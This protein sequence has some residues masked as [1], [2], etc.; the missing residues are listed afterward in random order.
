MPFRWRC[1]A[2]TENK[3]F[4]S[5]QHLKADRL[6]ARFP[7]AAFVVCVAR[8]ASFAQCSLSSR[9]HCFP[10]LAF[11]YLGG[12]RLGL[13]SPLHNRDCQRGH[14]VGRLARIF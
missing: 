11:S 10:L 5:L 6:A 12:L 4:D 3:A 1:Y 9:S 2:L 8:V 13:R 14:P 7:V